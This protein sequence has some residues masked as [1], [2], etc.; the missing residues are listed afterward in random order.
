MKRLLK[1][2]ARLLLLALVFAAGLGL[3]WLIRRTHTWTDGVGISRTAAPRELRQLMW[4]DPHPLELGLD[5][6]N[7]IEPAVSGD[8]RVLVF[9]KG[10]AGYNTG[11]YW[12][13]REGEG[14]TEPVPLTAL[15]SEHD[16]LGPALNRAGDRLWFYSDRP[17]GLGGYDIWTARRRYGE[18]EAPELL[19]AEINSIHDDYDPALDYGENQLAFASN[20]PRDPALL[21]GGEDWKGTLRE[22]VRSRQFDLYLAGRTDTDG[23]DAYRFDEAEPWDELNSPADEGQPTFSPHG[24]FVYFSSNRAGGAGGFDLYR[25]RLTPPDPEGPHALPPPVNGPDDE[26]DP[27]LWHEGHSLVFSSNRGQEHP[28][29]FTLRR[30]TSREVVART[31]LTPG[32]V[33]AWLEAHG[34]WLLLLALALLGIAWLWWL[35]YRSGATM[36]PRARALTLSALAHALLLFLLS[37]WFLGAELVE[38]SAGPLE[39][40][41]SE[42][43][44]AREKLS[45]E[46]REDVAEV[47][48][49]E[50]PPMRGRVRMPDEVTPP[51]L[52]EAPRVEIP[53]VAATQSEFDMPEIS[54]ETVSPRDL[55][56]PEPAPVEAAE[57]AE[58]PPM[59]LTEFSEIERLP[60]VEL[61]RVATREE[62]E[63]EPPGAP[64]EVERRR[65]EVAAAAALPET[66]VRIPE[67]DARVEVD[68]SE[69][70]RSATLE[71]GDSA[72]LPEVA[73]AAPLDSGAPALPDY[74]PSLTLELE[75]SP[76]AR[77]SYHLRDPAVRREMLEE[78]GGNDETEAAI[79]RALEFLARAQEEDGRWDIDRWGGEGGHDVAATGLAMLCFMGH[80]ATHTGDT[81]Y[82]P[83]MRKAVDWLLTRQ[84]ENGEFDAK[85]MYDHFIATIALAEAYAMSE[86]EALRGPLEKAVDF[87]VRAQHDGTGGWRY[88]PNQSGDTSVVGWALM[89]I[90]SARQSGLDLPRRAF[91]RTDDWFDRVAGGKEGGRYGY[92]SRNA[93]RRAM[94]AEG[95]F[96]RQLLNTP[97][98]RPDMRESAAY[99]LTEL[100]R[101]DDTDYY[102][103]YYGC[104]ALYQHQGEVWDAW[105]TRM[106]RILVDTQERNGDHAGS[107]NPGRDKKYGKRMGRI[108]TTAL[109]TLSL[110]VYYRYLPM[111]SR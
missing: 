39:V 42:Q 11:L 71:R 56:E 108:V 91:E 43:N 47:Q 85:D 28:L 68:A 29:N 24:D 111:Y 103:W 15:N 63:P 77:L 65:A 90:S 1:F 41:V 18:W 84:K 106:R 51:D 104:L 17:G 88:K 10:K 61:P 53:E 58:L 36:G 70:V 13:E 44:L 100:P 6:V 97:R 102:H 4:E 12:C 50:T 92:D 8:G 99:L 94:T 67:A 87:V 101:A 7:N 64:A 23:E 62:A 31:W 48:V 40:A 93:R 73:M 79:Q 54:E 74:T 3:P 25:L 37:V 49:P 32:N 35:L 21:A 5:E 46:L 78:L 110:E 52:P 9:A 83:L 95:F 89:A 19:G 76:E 80:G 30:T 14:W 59:E 96:S 45:L 55:P 98:D 16:E 86:D 107:W 20:R 34:L 69:A 75:T 33:R 72:E 66:R 27:A 38:Q 57:P 81:A 82:Q 22:R 26:M 2:L 105:N 109:A 60:E